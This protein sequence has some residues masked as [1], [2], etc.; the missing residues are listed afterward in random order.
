MRLET[1]I[2]Y[3]LC[4]RISFSVLGPTQI[5]ARC[6]RQRLHYNPCVPGGSMKLLHLLGGIFALALGMSHAV[7]A[8]W[9]NYPTPGTPR[10]RDGKP[11]LAAKAPRANG[12]PDLSGVWHVQS[13]S[14]EE[15]R[16]L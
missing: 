9:L 11:D 7:S 14:L 13:E 16:R 10:T 4:D 12:K 3:S 8:Q 1:R 2:F 15:K 5:T 6:Q